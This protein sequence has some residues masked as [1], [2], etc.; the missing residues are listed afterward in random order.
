MK[1]IHNNSLDRFSLPHSEEGAR[2]YV[3]LQRTTTQLR[4]STR[5][6]LV[7]WQRLMLISRKRRPTLRQLMRCDVN[8]LSLSSEPVSR[9]H[10]LPTL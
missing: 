4:R 2:L 6:R 1:T 3:N 5:T 8:Y 7:K 10:H 9:N